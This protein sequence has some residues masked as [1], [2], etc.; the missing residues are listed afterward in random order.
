MR[1][2]HIRI[3]FMTIEVLSIVAVAI[4]II[5][6]VIRYM[7]RKFCISL[8]LLVLVLAPMAMDAQQIAKGYTLSKYNVVPDSYNFLIHIPGDYEA[9]NHA[10]PLIIFLHGKSLCGSNLN[11]VKKYGVIDAAEKGKI[12]PAIV[13]APQNPGGSWNSRKINDLIDWTIQHYLV[14]TTRIYVL[15]MSLGGYGTLNFVCAYPQRVAAAMAL[16]GGCTAKNMDGLGDVPLW[17]MHGTADTK[18]SIN[19]S[20]RVVNYLQDRGK[21]NL[22]RYDWIQGGSHGLLARLFYLQQTYDW[23][24]CHDLAQNPREVDR[25]FDITQQDLKDVY[26]ELKWFK[27]MFEDE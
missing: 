22:L 23:L 13:L 25:Y 1:S 15:G 5:Y 19:E 4:F 17:I 10:T 6:A 24:F 27:G 9:Y 3:L 11:A 18:V 7:N 20:K 2:P 16:C 12:I 26:S 8:L 14:D 21:T